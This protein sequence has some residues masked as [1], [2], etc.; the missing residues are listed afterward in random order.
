M[1]KI[2][3]LIMAFTLLLTFTACSNNTNDESSSSAQQ[4]SGTPDSIS[5][6]K[7]DNQNDSSTPAVTGSKSLVIYF[8]WSGNTEN[9]AKSIQSQT[10]S[11]IFEIVPATPYSDDYDTVVDLAQEEQ[12]S[13]ARPAI[14]GTIK[15][16]A[17]YDVIYVGFPNWWGDMP[18]ILYTFFDT[19]DLSSKTIALFCTS[20]GSGLSGTVNEVKSLEPNAT[21]TEGLHIGSGSSS[22]PDKAVSEWLN[23]IGL[24]K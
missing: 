5:A 23:D 18:M 11:D 4:Q 19:Y 22:N 8:S 24:A 1:K 10:D 17:D 20:G 14:S 13:K 7:S 12:R 15:N 9:V 2:Y 21:V 16:I 3:S 6:D